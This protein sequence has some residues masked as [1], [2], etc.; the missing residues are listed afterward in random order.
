VAE[1]LTDQI[2]IEFDKVGA[3]WVVVAYL[4]ND[5]RMLEVVRQGKDPHV[6]TGSLI[7]G[8]PEELVYK[9]SKLI[10]K[11]TDP[12]KIE[13]L[14]A[15]LP[16]LNGYFLPRN[17][18]V[19]QSGKKG[20]HGLNYHEG[21]DRFSLE[22]GMELSDATRVR[23]LYTT[24]AYP[25]IPIWWGS[26]ETQLR[27]N[28]RTLVNCFGRKCRLLDAWGDELFRKAYSFLPQSTVAD[29]VNK[30]MVK[31]YNDE[32]D[33]F[34]SAELLVHVTDSLVMQYPIEDFGAMSEFAVKMALDYINPTLMYGTKEFTIDTKVTI[35]LDW[36]NMVEVDISE[37]INKTA[38][39]LRETWERLRG[40]AQVA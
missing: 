12:I 11:H 35:G 31:F 2:L 26:I 30:G 20:N 40:E 16:E 9:E 3:E 5:A 21:S 6:I 24:V 15:K 36:G 25:G 22:S 38:E 19:R 4:S 14:R 39:N 13:S 10:G 27:N 33:Y 29:S 34:R 18:S 32:T 37:D 23:E 28:D 7:S 17:M 8:M 1:L